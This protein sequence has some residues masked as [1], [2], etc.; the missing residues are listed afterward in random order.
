[1]KVNN[2]VRVY[3]VLVEKLG[4]R[5]SYDLGTD[6]MPADVAM[7]DLEIDPEKKRFRF[8]ERAVLA[9]TPVPTQTLA[10]T[11]PIEQATV[12]PPRAMVAG[13]G[14]KCST[15][16]VLPPGMAASACCQAAWLIGLAA[17]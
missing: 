5:F 7:V 10:P 13:K 4:D 6:G 1:M 15:V 2:T 16:R 11:E 12:M 3:P 14:S 9:E 17:T 8:T